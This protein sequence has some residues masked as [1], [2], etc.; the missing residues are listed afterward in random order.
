MQP[1]YHVWNC[2][3]LRTESRHKTISGVRRGYIKAT[4]PLGATMRIVIEFPRG[5]MG[6]SDSNTAEILAREK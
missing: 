1:I 3:T 5:H 4:K 2:E 6:F